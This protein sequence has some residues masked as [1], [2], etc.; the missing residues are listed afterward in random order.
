MPGIRAD[1]Q[2]AR[3]AVEAHHE[4]P[5]RQRRE[6]SP[7]VPG[8]RSPRASPR[9]PYAARRQRRFQ[10]LGVGI[11][12]DGEGAPVS[13]AG[14]ITVGAEHRPQRAPDEKSAVELEGARAT[15]A[16]HER[17]PPR[18]DPRRDRGSRPAPGRRR[19]RT[20]RRCGEC[21]RTR[22]GRP[23]TGVSPDPAPK[24]RMRSLTCSSESGVMNPDDRPVAPPPQKDDSRSTTF[25]LA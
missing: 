17:R 6:A 3:E 16:R 15:H 21:A 14:V 24:R 2:L 22:R 18:D 8:P 13:H 11:W 4:M 7:R 12:I 23:A 1:A 25:R 20:A 19:C 5:R 10:S 9:N